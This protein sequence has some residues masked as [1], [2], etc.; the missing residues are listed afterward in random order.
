VL[1][2]AS[3]T[4]VDAAI[5][6]N[7]AARASFVGFLGLPDAEFDAVFGDGAAKRAREE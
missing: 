6:A 2:S 4:A 5:L 3:A 7:F 1:E